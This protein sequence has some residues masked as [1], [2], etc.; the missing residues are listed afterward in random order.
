MATQTWNSLNHIES[1]TEEDSNIKVSKGS[2]FLGDLKLWGDNFGET[3]DTDHWTETNFGLSSPSSYSVTKVSNKLRIEAEDENVTA[4]GI[5][6]DLAFTGDFNVQ[7]DYDQ[8]TMVGS[9]SWFLMLKDLNNYFYIGKDYHLES[10]RIVAYTIVGGATTG[11]TFNTTETSI[12]FKLVRT[13]T[14]L[15]CY[16]DIGAGWVELHKYEGDTAIGN[17]NMAI[18]Q[19]PWE[20]GSGYSEW[21]NFIQNSGGVYWEDSPEVVIT[22]KAG[23]KATFDM[24]SFTESVTGS[25]SCK[26]QY[27]TDKAGTT[28]NGSWLTAHEMQIE[29]DVTSKYFKVKAQLISD[30]TQTVKLNS[31]EIDYTVIESTV[32]KYDIEKS[33]IP[34]DDELARVYTELCNKIKNHI[35]FECTLTASDVSAGYVDIDQSDIGISINIIDVIAVKTAMEDVSDSSVFTISDTA[36]TAYSYGKVKADTIRVTFGALY[37]TGDKCR[38]IVELKQNA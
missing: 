26:Y 17:T 24:S 13:G 32:K 18:A 15:Y 28:W 31:I 8:G 20:D 27:A 9:Q 11:V 19:L 35:T 38:G 1:V 33:F 22:Q 12:K 5:I 7:I 36:N 25:G 10:N 16:Y 3:L 2:D 34:K 14:Y 6:S 30:G 4:W 37:E 21:D 23:T 29:T